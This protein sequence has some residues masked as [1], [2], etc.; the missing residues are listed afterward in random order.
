[1]SYREENGCVILG[2]FVTAIRLSYARL[3]QWFR[4][5]RVK[6]LLRILH[7]LSAAL[8]RAAKKQAGY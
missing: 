4:K 5:K 2:L 3:R 1:M 7:Y 8:F 6:A